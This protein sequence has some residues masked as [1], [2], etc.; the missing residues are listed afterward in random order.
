VGYSGGM[1]R[2]K[3]LLQHEFRINNG[4]QTLF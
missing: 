2:K 4:V 3:W 1:W